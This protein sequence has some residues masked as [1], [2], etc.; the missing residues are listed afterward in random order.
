M[1]GHREQRWRNYCQN[2]QR[3][4]NM[5]RP[6]QITRLKEP[7]SSTYACAIK[8]PSK[9]L[10]DTCMNYTPILNHYS[11]LT[12]VC[13]ETLQKSSRHQ[14][15]LHSY[16]VNHPFRGYLCLTRKAESLDRN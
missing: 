3:S 2:V 6:S 5:M 4:L 10:Q 16:V 12:C 11:L 15:E 1:I 7:L 13:Y 14:Y 8:M 9:T